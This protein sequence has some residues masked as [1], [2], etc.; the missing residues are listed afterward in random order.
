[1]KTKKHRIKNGYFPPHFDLTF[2][3]KSEEQSEE[4]ESEDEL[5]TFTCIYCGKIKSKK[6]RARHT[7]SCIN[8]MTKTDGKK[9]VGND[10]VLQ[11]KIKYE[12]ELYEEKIK[13]EKNEKERILFEKNQILEQLNKERENKRRLEDMMKKQL[14]SEQEESKEMLQLY[15]EQIQM[16]MGNINRKKLGPNKLNTA[17]VI[18]NFTEAYNYEDLMAPDLTPE[19]IEL[20]GDDTGIVACFKLLKSRCID[21]IAIDKRPLHLVDVARKKYLIRTKGNWIHDQGGHKLIKGV[22]DKIKNLLEVNQ[23]KDSPEEIIHKN[24]QLIELYQN[25]YKILPYVNDH[26][27]LKNN[28]ISFDKS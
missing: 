7:K 9:K 4:A 26:I 5:D 17:F 27:I 2:E 19:E 11:I 22:T 8:K 13:N 12:K 25:S 18:S 3:N 10:S 21:G 23:D 15:R 16:L 6:N 1:L 28:A 14:V 24:Q 20:V